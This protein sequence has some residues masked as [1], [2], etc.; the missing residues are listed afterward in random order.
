M[1]YNIITGKYM[2]KWLNSNYIT[3][4][5]KDVNIDSMLLNPLTNYFNP[6]NLTDFFS[7]S[8][9]NPN[10]ISN[11]Q[12]F[13]NTNTRNTILNLWDTTLN[14]ANLIQ[15]NATL[16]LEKIYF[17]TDVLL[18][19]ELHLISSNI[20]AELNFLTKPKTNVDVIM[21]I[22]PE[23]DDMFEIMEV[24]SVN[25][26][27]SLYQ[28]IHLPEFKLY[29]PEPFIA[30][31]SFNHEQMWFI[32]ILHYQY[33][34]WFFFISL[35]W[36]FFITFINTVR[37][38]NPRNKPKRET[39]GVSRS[40]CADLITACVPVSWAMS[41]IISESVDAADYYD[42]FGTGEIVIGIRAYQ[43]GWEYFY[44]KNI[45][46]SYN[47]NPTYSTLTGNSLKYTKTT[48]ATAGTNQFWKAMRSESNINLSSTPTH[49]ILSPSDNNKILNFINFKNIGDNTI[50]NA[51]AF[52]KIQTST[53][54][55]VNDLF[56]SSSD[57][58]LKYNKINN[59]YLTDLQP[60]E[61]LAYGIKRQHEYG[62]VT[63]LSNSS[64]TC[65]D[66]KSVSKLLDYNFKYLSKQNNSTTLDI[67]SNTRE[68]L[69]TTGKTPAGEKISYN[70]N[71]SKL[72]NTVLI[73]RNYNLS[74]N[75]VDV[76]SLK[77]NLG[78]NIS[79]N[80]F[81]LKSPNNEISS[82][83][84][85]VRQLDKINPNKTNYNLN[86]SEKT[87]SQLATT[88]PFTSIPHTIYNNKFNLSFDKF[89]AKNT[90]AALLY[91]NEDTAP[92]F[93]FS[94]NWQ[95]L[96]G[97]SDVNLRLLNAN[98]FINLA[99]TV[100]MPN[101]NE[102]AGYD[103]LNWQAL[104][105]IEDSFWESSFS[106]Y[107]QDEYRNILNTTEN[108]H[109]IPVNK[110]ILINF[111]KDKE[112]FIPSLFQPITTDYTENNLENTA[113]TFFSEDAYIN[114]SLL[115]LLNFGVYST[116][117]EID[118]TEDSYTSNKFINYTHHSNYLNN[119]GLN[120]NNIQP[121]SYIQVLNAF[122]ARADETTNTFDNDY[123]ESYN[124][125]LN[126][127]ESK[128][129]RSMNYI[130]LRSTTK[131]AIKTFNAIHKV[132]RFRFDEGRSNVHLN[133][134]S[135]M[136]I[137]APLISESRVKY[138]QLLGK[139]KETFF[140]PINYK[141]YL[142]KNYSNLASPINIL[143]IYFAN[144]PFLLSRHSE[145]SRFMWFDWN[146][147]WNSIEVQPSSVSRYSLLGVPY[148]TKN[149]EY[150]TTT[151]DKM[152]GS[153]TYLIRLSKARKNYMS[154]WA[155]TPYMYNRLS[156]WYSLNGYI[157]NTLGLQDIENLRLTLKLTT[158]YWANAVLDT[159]IH[160]P[161]PSL[162]DH[163]TPNRSSAKPVFGLQGYSQTL[164]TLVNILTKREYLYREYF[165]NKGLSVNLPNY[166]VASPQN[167]LF[168]EIKHSYTF[169]D[170]SNF[171]TE[172]HR[173]FFYENTNLMRFKLLSYL[174][175]VN[176][177]INTIPFLNNIN[178]YLFNLNSSEDINTNVELYKN[179]YRPMRKGISNMIKLHAT[180]AIAMPIEIRLH[181]L[182]SSKDIIHSWA[183]PSAGIKMDCVP[184]YSSHRVTIFL[185]SGIFWGQC[186]EIC[187]RF[188]HWM[189]IIV[190]F[191][192]KDMFFLWC[193]HFVHFST[194]DLSFS[195]LDKEFSSKVRQVS[196][197]GNWVL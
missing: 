145:P 54:T 129:L 98:K 62:S 117:L 96:W 12:Y 189:P 69:Q 141:P 74:S 55:N 160:Q 2:T 66:N 163:L 178:Y 111:F 40:K 197:S 120:I 164:S 86:N 100:S 133:D 80:Q 89:T 22:I 142:S 106:G 70:T 194:N 155:L 43:W 23:H 139:N 147:R 143:N 15:Y 122:R 91:A 126:L 33:W 144:I 185:F 48:E 27:N 13:L 79:Y 95:T 130:K 192:K 157:G 32:H 182:C 132:F 184:G 65:L 82:E 149:F 9:K 158:K 148:F 153:E 156:N 170:P 105:L 172:V 53:K 134:F 46:L 128:E 45:D 3:D 195:T 67:L 135:N 146:T 107:S 68:T 6:V 169:T 116:E 131:S 165:L 84:R 140:S 174:I 60:Q 17:Y 175:N 125:D 177:T 188:H 191:M 78:Q 11:T 20:T 50:N 187:G 90:P 186:M 92:M 85:T 193:T 35:I 110:N 38:A 7:F 113:L 94:S 190:Y 179:Q 26:D 138:E 151:S 118:N 16:S 5:F 10:S 63:S 14:Q 34:L 83:E 25:I 180:G 152:N 52:K 112:D 159:T 93:I 71:K 114:P 102:Y 51:N 167:T 127:N 97:N 101:I 4:H 31:P 59:L 44:P 75:L 121:F 162:N 73:N 161:T 109:K 47:I 37:W 42:G 57:F 18:D 30:S 99:N 41:I 154:N 1:S 8:V 87:L 183:I 64:A 124:N 58:S 29:Y 115:P 108:Y 81:I 137:K 168:E 24:I 56:N 173:D 176:S 171:I 196:F 49:S 19:T 136:S 21:N 72:N 39:R 36:L 123:S 88:Y 104:E 76:N 119:M 103:F 181:L 77:S 61:S 150:A 28:F 166:L